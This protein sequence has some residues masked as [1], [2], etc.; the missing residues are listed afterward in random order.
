MSQPSPARPVV[1]PVGFGPGLLSPARTSM[2]RR[3]G[4]EAMLE[5]GD[6]PVLRN[7]PKRDIM[8]EL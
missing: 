2:P 7:Y 6:S 8:P 3:A 4:A 5:G 1:T